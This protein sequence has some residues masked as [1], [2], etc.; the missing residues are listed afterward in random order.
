M[1]NIDNRNV[2][3]TKAFNTSKIYPKSFIVLSSFAFFLHIFVIV[4]MSLN[5]KLRRKPANKFLLNLVISD[6][7]VC[8][9]FMSYTANLLAIWEDGNTFFESTLQYI[10]SILFYVVIILSMLNFTL[11]TADRL[12]AVKWPF[13]YMDR[14]HTKQSLIAIAILWGVAIIYAIVMITLF[15]VLDGETSNY[16]GDITFIAVVITGFIT[17]FISNSF[18]FVEGRRHLRRGEIIALNINKNS[19]EPRD[20]YSNKERYFRKKEFKLVRINIGLILCFLLFWTNVIILNIRQIV[21]IDGMEK[22]IS[23][24]Y[25]VASWYLVH[26]YYICNPLFHVALSGDVKREVT[27]FFSGKRVAES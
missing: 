3:S 20:K 21:H 26:I 12:I 24:E 27:E 15:S 2:S 16:L 4:L 5:K 8:I 22:S 1:A 25:I 13:F 19:V 6:A 23:L 7:V 17:L 14:I 9:S 18:V 11:I 10:P